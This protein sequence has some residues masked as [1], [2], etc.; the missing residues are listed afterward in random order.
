MGHVWLIGMMGSGK[1]TVGRSLADR[2]GQPFYDTDSMVEAATGKPIAE[3]FA[4]DG[5]ERFRQLES[6][7]IREIAALIDGVVAT[8][9]GVVLDRTNVETMR[10][11]GVTVLL[12]APNDTLVS[13]VSQTDDRPLIVEDPEESLS[14]IA[15]VRADLY[16]AAASVTVDADGTVEEVADRV[17]AAC[18]GF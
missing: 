4:D 18:A 8:G 13:R 5:E 17:E 10:S 11:N 15:S 9:G 6:E 2:R 1:T 12:D 7:A 3:I 16:A 14:E